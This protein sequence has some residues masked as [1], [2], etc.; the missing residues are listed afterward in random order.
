MK[1]ESFSNALSRFAD[2]VPSETK[3]K[4]QAIRP[5]LSKCVSTRN[6]IAHRAKLDPSV[7]LKELVVGMR[8]LALNLIWTYN[9]IPSVT[10]DVPASTVSLRN[11]SVAVRML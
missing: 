9:R 8:Q 7:N 5:F 1:E 11:G 3:V 10:V 2:S 6:R 4:G